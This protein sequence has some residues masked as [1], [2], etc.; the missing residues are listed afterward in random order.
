MV[1][2]RKQPVQLLA[3]RCEKPD[4]DLARR[5]M[6]QFVTYVAY[7]TGTCRVRWWGEKMISIHDL[8]CL[9]NTI[10][11]HSRLP[12]RLFFL[13]LVD[14]KSP[15]IRMFQVVGVCPNQYCRKVSFPWIQS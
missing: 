5:E 10:R 12:K 6:L 8:V 1:N 13:N 2:E 9:F 3:I 4:L 15:K 7:T 14:G 11:K